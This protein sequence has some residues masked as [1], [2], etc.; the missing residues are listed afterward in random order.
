MNNKT[1]REQMRDEYLS[2]VAALYKQVINWI[3]GFDPKVQIAEESITIKEEPVDPYHAKVLVINRPNYKTIRLIPRGRWIIGAEGRVDV[4]SDLGTETLVYVSEGGPAIRIDDLT[5]NG[6][7]LEE[8]RPCAPAKDVAE[9]WVF[10]QNRQ[11]GMLPSLDA[12][13]FH[14]LLEVLGR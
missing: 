3:E 12:S 6:K 4:K 14:R 7:I 8:G 13:L 2:R 10:V 1:S 5:E 9:G 11:I